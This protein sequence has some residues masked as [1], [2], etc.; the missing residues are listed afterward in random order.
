MHDAR[1]QPHLPERLLLAQWRVREGKGVPSPQ[2]IPILQF[3]M[4]RS[5]DPVGPTTRWTRGSTR[6]HARTHTRK[7]NPTAGGSRGDQ[8]TDEEGYSVY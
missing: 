7:N 3:L 4:M 6:T 1:T 8:D 2:L 5:N